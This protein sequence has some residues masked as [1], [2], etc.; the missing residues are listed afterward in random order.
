M[1]APPLLEHVRQLRDLAVRRRTDRLTGTGP[2]PCGYYSPDSRQ[3]LETIF[4]DLDA[5]YAE[6]PDGHARDL[7][8]LRQAGELDL[9]QMTSSLALLLVVHEQLAALAASL[10]ALLLECDLQ[11]YARRTRGNPVL[12][13]RLLDEGLR[14]GLSFPVSMVTPTRKV[15]LAGRTLAKGTPVL[16][17]FAAANLDPERFG[18][19]AGAFDP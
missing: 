17:S 14:R 4:Q 13:R 3:E 7:V 6:L 1:C 8:Q 12:A 15:T 11:G 9:R 10:L 19:G 18:P 2:H 5:R 16:V